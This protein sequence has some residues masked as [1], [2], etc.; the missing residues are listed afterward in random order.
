MKPCGVRNIRAKLLWLL[1]INSRGGCGVGAV[2]RG[3]GDNFHVSLSSC[4]HVPITA[5]L[6]ITYIDIEQKALGMTAL[7][8]CHYTD[9]ISNITTNMASISAILSYFKMNP[10]YRHDLN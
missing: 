4:I 7:Q 8:W 3:C 9:F 6:D 2:K 10:T 5:S 1:L